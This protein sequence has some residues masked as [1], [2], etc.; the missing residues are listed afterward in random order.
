M[1]LQKLSKNEIKLALKLNTI[2]R[3][4]RNIIS[5]GEDG[6]LRNVVNRIMM[7]RYVK[8]SDI[9]ITVHPLRNRNDS[10]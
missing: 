6:T 9:T 7:Q 1:F 10:I 8:S 2:L 3:S 4:F 5:I